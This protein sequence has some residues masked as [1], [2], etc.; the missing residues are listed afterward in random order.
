M[1]ACACRACRVGP[2]SAMLT[3]TLPFGFVYVRTRPLAGLPLR[4]AT[5]VTVKPSR[6]PYALEPRSFRRALTTRSG[7]GTPSA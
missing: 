7:S 3:L 4:G 1:C 5:L 2:N 6:M